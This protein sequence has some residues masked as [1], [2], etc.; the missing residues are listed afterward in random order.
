MKLVRA[1]LAF[2]LLLVVA[3]GGAEPARSPDRAQEAKDPRT[4][5]EALEQIADA[6][7]ELGGRPSGPTHDRKDDA[8]KNEP[9]PPP[10]A[11]PPSAA[12]APESE[13]ATMA[14][15][16]C[17]SPCRAFVSMKRAVEALCRLAGDSDDRCLKARRT[18]EDSTTRVASCHCS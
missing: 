10:A 1:G 14:V 2:S 4:I 16:V 6:Q 9:A 15:D 7:A 3:C 17:Q 11:A 5:E 13:K 18:L 12:S 8:P